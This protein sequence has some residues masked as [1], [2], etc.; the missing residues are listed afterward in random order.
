[1]SVAWATTI[2]VPGDQA[3][4]QAAID[5]ASNGDSVLVGDGVYQEN[6]DFKGK[7][8]T[9][10]SVKGASTTTIDG[11]KSDYAVKFTTNEGRASVLDGFTVTN[12]FPG[13][14]N[15]GGSS[16]TVQNN[17]I[18]ANTGCEGIGINVG[19]AAPLIQDN[20]ISNNTQ[21]G[22]S[23]GVGGGGIE[24]IG[25]SNG[26][27]IIGNTI[28]GNNSGSGVN[29]GGIGLWT[30][31]PV[32]ILGNFISGNT[33]SQGGGIGGANDTSAV[34]IIGNVITGNTAVGTGGGV[35]I[36]N[37]VALILN[38]TIANNDGSG[39]GSAFYGAFSTQIAPMTVSNNLI[40]GK[41]GQSALGCRTFDTVNPIVFSFN[42]VF[43]PG[44]GSYGSMCVDQT[45][46]NGNISADPVFVNSSGS[47]F[48]LQASSPAIDTGSNSASALPM[49]DIAG[50]DRML[51]GNGDCVATV[52]MGAYEFARAS[53]LTLSPASLSFADQD[54][55]STSAVFSSKITNTTNNALTLCGIF[56]TGDFE[57]TNT[58]A[59]GIAA[60]GSCT[61]NVRFA[62]A[63]HGVR[64]GL[65][66]V[67]SNDA[68][69][70]QS[71]A[72]SGKGVLPSVALSTATVVF[73]AQLVGTTGGSQSITLSNT[74][75]GALNISNVTLSG[76]FS[77][78]NTCGNAIMAMSSCTFTIKFLP[79][80]T[81]NR[82]G[83]LTIMD[84]ASGS[85]RV[86][87]LTGS[88]TDFALAMAPG[89]SNTSTVTAG[90]TAT[91]SLQVSPVN[92][93]TGTVT[94][95]C[96]GAPSLAACNVTPA[97]VGV[98]GSSATA[99]T[100]TVS[101]TAGS[102]MAS[103]KP[104]DWPLGNPPHFSLTLLVAMLMFGLHA[105]YKSRSGGRK[106]GMAFSL[107]LGLV[108]FIT[109]CG[110]GH[111]MQSPGTPK[112]TFTLTITGTTAGINHVQNL[113]LT[114][115]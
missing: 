91:Y 25:A 69:S 63:A 29:G 64:L 65:V 14:I 98:N 26:A 30:P 115:E 95:S 90:N 38:N 16:P 31:G 15:I 39:G 93:F 87:T 13:G 24:V 52:D 7:A 80:V 85:P 71:I 78:S 100:A 101:T 55:G 49:A 96:T 17:I 21:A 9:V 37:A 54:I 44:G 11:N 36:D 86:V 23:G 77:E 18:T 66:Q 28:T 79:T 50:N 105:G 41:S 57:Q 92:G 22:C 84:N 12:G 68:G 99:F 47:D 51:D 45:G 72:L 32:L 88:A 4:I 53:V 59:S 102:M 114:V 83:A 33:A 58:C 107:A 8:I 1:L 19:G 110:G 48:K 82:A 40:I 27:Q 97:S 2:H 76:E 89:S 67:I 74:G 3:T 60:K 43:S 61:V 75:D 62:P 106:I 34:R 113:T 35:E 81:G 109:G 94:L 112:G 103:L 10:K 20:T 70:P 5:T 56:V 6:I 111:S 73:P 42:D 46:Q 108:L 104:P